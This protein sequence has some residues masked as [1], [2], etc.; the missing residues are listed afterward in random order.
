MYFYCLSYADHTYNNM[1]KQ[2]TCT[3][4]VLKSYGYCLDYTHHTYNS[5]NK[6]PQGTVIILVLLS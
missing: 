4:I 2:P 5:F 6:Q 3:D 1:N